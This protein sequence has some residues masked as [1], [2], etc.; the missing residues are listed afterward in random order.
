MANHYGI[1]PDVIAG[2]LPGLFPDGFTVSTKPTEAIV[3]AIIAREDAIAYIAAKWIEEID[4][5]PDLAAAVTAMATNYVIWATKWHVLEIVYA[6][7][8]PI[9]YANIVGPA[10]DAAN[11]YLQ[12][13]RDLAIAHEETQG[14]G[15]GGGLGGAL[16]S[17]HTSTRI[18]W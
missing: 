17:M 11:Q 14:S 10:R 2:E 6:G 8:D 18:T 1:T 9:A 12:G 13:L 5:D 16:P 4:D 7:V 15:S 3:T